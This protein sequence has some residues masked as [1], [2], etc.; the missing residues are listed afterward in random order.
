MPIDELMFD[1]DGLERIENIDTPITQARVGLG[2]ITVSILL[3]LAGILT[4]PGYD[5][6]THC[7][8][9]DLIRN[10]H[11]EISDLI[12]L[13]LTVSQLHEGLSL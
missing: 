11:E 2:A 12:K 5:D 8:Q 9:L 6:L 3:S 1:P 7:I 10:D 4:R 13:Q